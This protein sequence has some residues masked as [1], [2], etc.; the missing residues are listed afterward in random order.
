MCTI[1]YDSKNVV[2]ISTNERTTEC[3]V[4]CYDLTSANYDTKFLKQI[5][6]EYIAM[7]E[8]EQ[9]IPNGEIICIP[10]NDNGNMKVLI[11]TSKG[12]ELN[13]IDCNKIC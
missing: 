5:E 10:Y 11:I 7:N 6:G 4:G 12:L 1:T 9:N 13:T 3:E 8:I 2:V